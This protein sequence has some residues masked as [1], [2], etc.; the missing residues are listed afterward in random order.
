MLAIV[1][2]DSACYHACGKPAENFKKIVDGVELV[3]L[4]A[5]G[6]RVPQPLTPAQERKY[7]EDCWDK[8]EKSF[9][10]TLDSVFATEYLMAVKSK[11]NFRSEVYAEYK[12]NRH[13]VMS[14]NTAVVVPH[15]RDLMVN[16]YGAIYAHNAEADDYIRIWALE[17]RAAGDPYI[18]CA[19]D[20]DLRCI[21]GLH[22]DLKKKTIDD[23]SEGD[24]MRFMYEQ[25]ISG[26]QTDKIPGV[27]GLG[28]VKV[29]KMVAGCETEE[30]CQVA[31]VEAYFNYYGEDEWYNQLLSNGKM[32]YMMAYPGDY[33]RISHWPIVKEIL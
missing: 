7:L 9:Q 8:L 21:P 24:A 1:D 2:V 31:V 15:L 16:A 12:M 28:P 25:M 10:E 32:T 20:K 19:V 3:E 6:R 30:D 33:F 29:K 17:A 11:T 4:D 14:N 27:P 5:E 18:I 26:D 13:A 23:V 22:Y